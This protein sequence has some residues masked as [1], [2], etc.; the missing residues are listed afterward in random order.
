MKKH[1]WLPPAFL[2][3]GVINFLASLWCMGKDSPQ[4]ATYFVGVAIYLVVWAIYSQR[5]G[6]E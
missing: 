5:E 4:N 2:F 3:V 6:S 1:K